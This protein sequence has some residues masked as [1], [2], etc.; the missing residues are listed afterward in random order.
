MIVLLEA[1]A[2]IPGEVA[3]LAGDEE[4][5]LR[6]R[7]ARAGDRVE[8][9]DGAGLVGT[10]RLLHDQAGWAVEVEER[11]V[12]QRGPGLTLAVG[13]GDRERFEWLVEKATEL[14]VKAVVPTETARAA[15]VATRIRAEHVPKLR[16]RALEALKQCGAAWVPEIREPVPLAVLLADQEHGEHWLADLDGSPAAGLPPSVVLVGP[17]GGLTTDERVAALG[18]GYR[19]VRLGAHVLRFETAAIV[20]AAIAARLD[21]RGGTDG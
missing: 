6:V 13:A 9:R 17:E 16:K 10:G 15:A 8:I 3:R 1:K 20:A 21:E 11:R 2:G 19:P 18:A 7:R 4:H 14:G 12:S 5:H